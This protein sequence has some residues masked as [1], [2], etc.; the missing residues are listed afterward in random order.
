MF[1]RGEWRD[2]NYTFKHALVQDAAYQSLLR[3]RRAAFHARLVEVLLQQ[4][5]GIRRASRTCWPT[6]ASKAA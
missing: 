3:G 4:G 2:A 5:S 1:Q 6:I